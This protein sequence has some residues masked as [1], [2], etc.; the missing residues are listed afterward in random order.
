MRKI[1]QRTFLM[2]T[3]TALLTIP[4]VSTNMTISAAGYKLLP[5]PEWT[6]HV[7][8]DTTTQIHSK[9]NYYTGRVVFPIVSELTNLETAYT[10]LYKTARSAGK[11]KAVN[12]ILAID[13]KTG[14]QKWIHDS[15]MRY[16]SF[17][18]DEEG[19][20]YYYDEV[21]SGNKK[22]YKLI[23]LDSNNKQRWVK[24]FKEHFQFNILEDGRIAVVT[25]TK[26]TSVITIYNQEGKQLIKT[27]FPGHMR[28]IQGN[29]VGLI[30]SN[31][32][33]STTTIDIY[34][35]STGKKVVTAVQPQDH[36]NIVHAD[37]EVLSG[38]TVI[39][40]IYDAKTK[41][42]TLHG[43]KSNGE[44]KW[45]RR[46]PKP[47]QDAVYGTTYA[48]GMYDSIYVSL[49][50]NYLIQEKNKL[51]LYNTNN[52]LIATKTFDDLPAQGLLQQ[53]NDYSIVFGATD[54]SQAWYDS[55]KPEPKKAVYYIL[56][57]RTLKVKNTLEL[58][59]A[60]FHQADIRFHDEN[61]FY[62]HMGETITKY[63]LK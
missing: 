6:Y 8:S 18:L 26:D 40:P 2:T 3:L 28:H 15:P 42:E 27:E 7:P 49:G 17:D 35:I 10:F 41:V 48:H 25:F 61:T 39:V 1:I 5:K 60:L 62:I 47:A 58:D 46:L 21:M 9:N 11:S 54:K 50:N 57:S 14:K 29:Y 44:E 4:L 34:S 23:A 56:D 19:N 37:F 22:V 43:Y 52:Q 24:T 31:A 38:G 59:D 30:N 51:S 16:N 53:L 63:V 12:S 36:V 33:R 20:V 13:D 55:T 32:P 45:T